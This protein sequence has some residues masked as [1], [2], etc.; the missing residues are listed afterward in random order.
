MNIPCLIYTR[1]CGYFAPTIQMNNGKREEQR[2]RRLLKYDG[3]EQTTD[4]R[5]ME[6]SL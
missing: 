4:A 6:E 1:T 2:E 5:I 3:H